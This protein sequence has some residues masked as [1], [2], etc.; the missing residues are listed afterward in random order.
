MLDV[1]PKE[2]VVRARVRPEKSD[3]RVEHRQLD[4]LTLTRFFSAEKRSTERLDAGIG[5]Q[6]IKDQL[7][8]L[9]RPFA[10]LETLNIRHARKRLNNRI[11]RSITGPWPRLAKATD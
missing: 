6:F 1:V 5:C 8:H 11:I 10:S 3:R 2:N 4:V 9:L 7:I